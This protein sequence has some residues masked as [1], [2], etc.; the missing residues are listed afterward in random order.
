MS[1]QPV[2]R[3]V[4]LERSVNYRYRCQLKPVPK[5]NEEKKIK[6]L[7]PQN[8]LFL[9]NGKSRIL[10]STYETG[11]I[12][13]RFAMRPSNQ[14]SST[15]LV[16]TTNSPLHSDNSMADCALKLNFARACPSDGFRTGNRMPSREMICERKSLRKMVNWKIYAN[17]LCLHYLDV[18]CWQQS[19]HCI[20]FAFVPVFID[21]AANVNDVALFKAQFSV[22]NN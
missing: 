16:N 4:L 19:N 15:R 17:S 8:F 5:S 21:F 2:H 13:L 22:E 14:F 11:K 10:T 9:S 12:P 3:L 18:I 6:F 1:G 20:V 7:F